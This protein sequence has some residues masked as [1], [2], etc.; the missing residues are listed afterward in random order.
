[1]LYVIHLSDDR[2]FAVSEAYLEEAKADLIKYG[3]IE[4]IEGP[5]EGFE[6]TSVLSVDAQ[7]FS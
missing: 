1:M 7:D 4:H 5:Y 6:V 2:V 3:D